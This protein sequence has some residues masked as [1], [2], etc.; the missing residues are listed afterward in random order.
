MT[1][2][3]ADFD[4]LWDF[5][6]P[7]TTEQKFRA[8]LSREAPS[9]DPSRHAQLLT[10]IARAQGLQRKF[11]LAHETLD[12]V[13][14]MLADGVTTARVRYLLERGRLFNSS[15]QPQAARPIFESAWQLARSSG[16]DFFAIDAAHMMAIVEPS[17][18]AQFR[19]NQTAL[20]LAESSPDE[21]ARGWRGSLYNNIGW[22]CFGQADYEKAMEVFTK[23]VELRESAGRPREVRVA[24][25]CVA[26]TLRAQGKIE[27]ALLISR[28]LVDE[29]ERAS[30]PDGYLLEELG[31]C[32]L[33]RGS[34]DDARPFFRRAHA[35]LSKN[36][37][38]AEHEPDRLRRLEEL[39]R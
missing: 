7:A 24:R 27:Q 33:A 12:Q 29:A 31:E 35:E 17:P 5:N 18:L 2:P 26:R 34:A 32:L 36:A 10:Q 25:Y 28:A 1:V 8:L 6:D 30:E 4:Q 9:G 38:L 11:Q 14:Q 22:T 16:L 15:K 23:A 39:G 3:L 37:S 19:W 13:E 20:E 21:R